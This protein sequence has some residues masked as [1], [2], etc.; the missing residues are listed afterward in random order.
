MHVL[1]I[2]N[3]GKQLRWYQ[4]AV[5]GTPP[6]KEIISGY[7]CFSLLLI[8]EIFHNV[9]FQGLAICTA[10]TMLLPAEKFMSS[11]VAMVGKSVA[12]DSSSSFPM[13]VTY[14]LFDTR[15]EY[16]NDLH[17]LSTKT[18]TWRQVQTTGAIPK[19]RANHSSAILEETGELFIFGGW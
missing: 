6:G 14:L 18:L 17:A 10:L 8:T 16:L 2:S 13:I 11:G 9:N 4:P 12:P 15:R 3:G 19:Q 1:D 7:D 5:K